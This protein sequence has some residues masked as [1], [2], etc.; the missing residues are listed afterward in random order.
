MTAVGTSVSGELLTRLNATIKTPSLETSR[1]LEEA[2]RAAGY[3]P[4]IFGRHNQRA[5]IEANAESD[6]GAAE[7]LANAF[8][9]SLTAARIAM[10]QKSERALTPRNAAQ[11]YFCSDP[12]KSEWHPQYE[13]LDTIKPPIVQFW[14]ED[15]TAKQRYRKF[16]PGDGLATVLVRDSGVGLGREEMARTILTLNTDA[17]LRTFEAI[18]QFG[19]GGSSSLFFCE[20]ALVMTQPRFDVGR[21][22]IFWTLIYPEKDTDDSKQDLIR[23]WFADADGL[24][25]M[26]RQTDLIEP[27]V[28][29]GTSVWHFGY[30]RGGWIK[31][32]AG[33]T[34]TNPWGRLGRLFFSYPLPFEVHGDLA[35]TDE[36]KY[37]TISSPFH[38]LLKEKTK[39]KVTYFVPEKRERLI[40]DGVEYGEFSVVA[41][42]LPEPKDVT[43]Y[44]ES[45]HPIVLTLNGQ[46][47]GEMTGTWLVKANLPDLSSSMIV[48]VRL[49]GIEQEALSH[50]ITNSRENPKST[51]FTAA[52]R[53]R[54]IALLRDD[55]GLQQI[56]RRRAEEK[57]NK[58]NREFNKTLSDFLKRILSDAAGKAAP[59]GGRGGPGEGTGGTTPLPEVPG[60]DPPTVLE[61]ISAEPIRVPEGSTRLA[62]FKSDAR[63]PKYAFS[64]DNPRLF[65]SFDPSGETGKRI[66]IIGQ[67]EIN[68]RG[69]G[70]VSLHC[71]E[72]VQNPV[73]EST[74]AGTL[75]LKLQSTTG[76][77][78]TASVGILLVPKPERKEKTQ[79]PEVEVNI[80]FCAPGGD[81]D[82]SLS[83]VLGETVSPFGAYL[84]KYKTALA[85]LAEQ[86]YTYWGEKYD[87][88][89]VSV[90]N[91]EI[92]VA[93]PA[94]V[95]LMNDCA[96][97]Q[98][99]TIAKQRYCEDVVLDCYQHCF[100]LQAVPDEVWEATQ[101][102][103]NESRKASEMC[104]NHD[105]AVR[106]AAKERDRIRRAK[107]EDR[108]E[109]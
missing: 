9:A 88:E 27:S 95:K 97:V 60:N 35:R 8:D 13:K 80:V 26:V 63:P 34:Q 107:A 109:A 53:E 40:V 52:L 33:P 18:G 76:T 96:N 77:E 24:P 31:R 55:D 65:A 56:E 20:S 6:R 21:E 108:V 72:D 17:K 75:N 82:G 101:D 12:T 48:E 73:S 92:N 100:R 5:S 15:Q 7:R 86:D 104:L 42:V 57:A 51:I 71:S 106:F 30:H 89:G 41:F 78:L 44:L 29:P 84:D 90:L 105:K 38:R 14:E 58:S 46:N 49:D 25:L 32:I 22:N 16:N 11:R 81:P 79:M 39:G 4:V 50:I 45:A 67:A 83:A 47:H 69:Y 99:R 23:M 93:N 91:V 2:L 102:Q 68:D 70:S 62:K 1:S 37:R 74:P 28:F 36:G 64:G 85:T 66:A 103:E 3:R 59:S 98:E 61:F 94:I 87:K 19:H 10:G 54:L 43:N